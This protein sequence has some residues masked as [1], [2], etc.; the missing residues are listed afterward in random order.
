MFQV[1]KASRQ[2]LAVVQL[3]L[4]SNPSLPCLCSG[5]R[6]VHDLSARLHLQGSEQ[7]AARHMRAAVQGATNSFYTRQYDAFQKITNNIL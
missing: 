5:E 7:Q 3:A 4:R 6:T 1:R 2:L